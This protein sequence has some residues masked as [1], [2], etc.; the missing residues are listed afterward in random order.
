M[1]SYACED[2]NEYIKMAEKLTREML[3][4]RN[5]E[6]EDLFFGNPPEKK[7]FDNALKKIL[8]NI[9]KLSTRKKL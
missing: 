9:S 8:E 3:K 7:E 6:I 5:A 4:Y 1:L 2:E